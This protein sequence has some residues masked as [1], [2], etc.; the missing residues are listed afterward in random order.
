MTTATLT[1]TNESAVRAGAD[2]IADAIG[3]DRSTVRVIRINWAEHLR[4][5]VRVDLLIGRWRAE[6][7]LTFEDVGIFFDSD[8]TRDAYASQV[9]LGTLYLLPK[10]W[11]RT[12]NSLEDKA[13]NILNKYSTETTL[14]VSKT[15]LVAVGSFQQWHTETIECRAMY[16]AFADKLQDEWDSVMS[17]TSLQLFLIG[18]DAFDRLDA[19]DRQARAAGREVPKAIRDALGTGRDEFATAFAQRMMRKIP[20]R[21]EVRESFIFDWDLGY[22]P[23]QEDFANDSAAAERV[24]A[25]S[26]ILEGEARARN[27]AALEMQREVLRRGE[28]M[29]ERLMDTVERDVRAELHRTAYNVVADVL[30][31]IKKNE[32]VPGASVKQLR[33]IIEKIEQF[34]FWDEPSLDRALA[35]FRQ[36][37]NT[38]SPADEKANFQ[39]VLKG[40]GAEARLALLDLDRIDERVEDMRNFGIPTSRVAL[41]RIVNERNSVQIAQLELGTQASPITL[42]RIGT[43][44]GE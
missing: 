6:R 25:E 42:E 31:A 36:L 23:L 28:A 35:D 1:A 29:R 41:E 12:P 5:M 19:Y 8:E 15:R 26:E 21:E 10:A 40:I 18:R 30:Q 9:K 16:R 43:L 7:G 33:N 2:R 44:T 13:R 39:R 20:S 38:A 24:R 27:T 22:L 4:D 11:R 34:K 14:G 3:V 37:A 32:N 17:Q